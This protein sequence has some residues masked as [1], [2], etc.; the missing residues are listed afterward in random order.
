MAKKQFS[1]EFEAY[2]ILKRKLDAF[3]GDITKKAIDRALK[4]TQLVVAN[5]SEAAMQKHDKTGKTSDSIIKDGKVEWTGTEAKIWVGF[6][7]DS[8]G[9]AS[10]FLMHG[11]TVHGQP[12]V[13]PD[14]NLYNAVYGSA[15]RKEVQKIQEEAF[16]KALEEAMQT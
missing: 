4:D 11:T 8:G 7:I 10:I 16:R 1:V 15:V 6:D 3:G 5:A 13:T 2:D 12:H 14:R 9:L